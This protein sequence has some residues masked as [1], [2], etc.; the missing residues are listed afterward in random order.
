LPPLAT[1]AAPAS[2]LPQALQ[3]FCPAGLE[4]LQLEHVTSVAKEAPHSPQKAALGRFS[5]PH[6]GQSI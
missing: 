3:N 2:G 4:A 6:E 5:W 1:A